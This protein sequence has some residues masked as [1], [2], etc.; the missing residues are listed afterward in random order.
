MEWAVSRVIHFDF[1]L[2]E[3]KIMVITMTAANTVK[4]ATP[5]N[6][7][8]LFM[9]NSYFFL[10]FEPVKRYSCLSY[11]CADRKST[12]LFFFQLAKIKKQDEAEIASSAEH[13][14]KATFFLKTNLDLI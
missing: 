7:N 12:L 1:D 6:K 8:K 9:T 2:F 10:F 3:T 14:T 4:K 13:L 5:A 11:I